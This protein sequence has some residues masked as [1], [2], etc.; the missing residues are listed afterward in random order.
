[1]SVTLTNASHRSIA[2]ENG[3]EKVEFR[4]KPIPIPAGE[5]P[6]PV[7]RISQAK[8]RSK[9]YQMDTERDACVETRAYRQ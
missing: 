8:S 3:K 5:N 4:G 7:P 1:M 6:S 2:R 9:K